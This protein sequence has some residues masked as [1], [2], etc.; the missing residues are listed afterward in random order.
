MGKVA[1]ESR[2]S[3]QGSSDGLRERKG[4]ECSTRTVSAGEE[5]RRVWL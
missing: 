3:M 4:E 2:V 1:R 5:L